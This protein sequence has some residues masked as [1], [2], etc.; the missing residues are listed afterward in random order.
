MRQIARSTIC[1]VL[2][3]FV[4]NCLAQTPAVKLIPIAKGWAKNQNNTVIFRRNS[5]VSHDDVQYVA[6]YDPEGKVVLAKRRLGSASWDI[7][8]TQYRGDVTDAHKS[9][10]IAI[11]GAG[12]LHMA[13]NQH[14]SPLQYCRSVRPGSLELSPPLPMLPN[15]EQSVSYPEF[16]NLAGGDLLFLYRDGSS[17]KGNLVMNRYQVKT[18]RWFRVQ[19]N[20]IDG[21]NQRSA[22]WQATIDQGGAIH[23]SWV[24]RETPD[25]ASN[26]DI[27]YAKSIDGGKA[28]Q[29]SSGAKYQLPITAR[30]A[31][32]IVRIPQ[33]SDLIN[34]TS[35]TTDEFGR[36]YIAT[37]W[38]PAGAQTPQ[39]Q[40]VYYDGREWK[41]S[42]V[43]KRSTPFT[44]EGLG[45]RRIPISRPQVLTYSIKRKVVVVIVFRDAERG[46]RVSVAIRKDSRSDVWERQDLTSMSVGMWEPTFDPNIWH[47]RKTLHLFVQAVGQGQAESLE[48]VGPQM[49]NVLEWSPL[50]AEKL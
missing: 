41:T 36:P 43:T 21:E 19:D 28:W 34:Q 33:R 10:S 44:L 48:D 27:C 39:Y 12:I 45:T 40:L 31:E 6:F 18:A 29:K 8:T 24:W 11:D 14:N 15:L 1:I 3:S 26:H 9:I 4:A 38:K 7:R 25:V 2:L 23:L 42:Q 22:Y 5:I 47:K 50:I 16:Y 20:L 37:Y 13:W 49:V 46:D 30:S 35:M 32:Y 17:G